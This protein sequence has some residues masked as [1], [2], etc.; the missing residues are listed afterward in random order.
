LRIAAALMLACC[1]PMSAGRAL[2]EEITVQLK[3]RHQF[4]FAGYYAALEKGF[5]AEEGLNVRLI[6]GGPGRPPVDTLLRGGADYA[7]A[8]AG[9]LRYR[10]RGQPVVVLASIFQ[11][12]PLVLLCLGRSGLARLNDLRGKRLMLQRGHAT[13]ILAMLHQ[14][15]IGKNDFRF[16][17]TSSQLGDLILGRVDAFAAYETNEPFVLQNQGIPYRMFRPRDY[18][19]DFYGDTLITTE[20]E[21]RNHPER[22]AAFRRATLRGWRYAL[23]HMDEVI[24]LIKRQYDTQHK[25]RAHLAF[26]AQGIRDLMMADVV[27]IGLSNPERWQAIARTFDSLGIPVEHVDWRVFLYR[28]APSFGSF[29]RQHALGATMAG[30]VLALLLATSYIL[31]LL[32]GRARMARLLAAMPV[33]LFVSRLDNGS[34][35]FVNDRARTFS[36][37]DDLGPHRSTL[38]FYADPAERHRIVRQILETGEIAGHE[39]AVR[40]ADGGIR[41]VS[42]SAHR[43]RFEGHDAMISVIQDITETIRSRSILKNVNQELEQRVAERTRELLD[44]NTRLREEIQERERAEQERKQLAGHLAQAQKMES[45]GVLAG[46]V[47]HDFNNLLAGIMGNAELA[48]M[49][50]RDGRMREYL[51]PIL[52]ASERGAS[53]VRHLLDYAGKSGREQ[54]TLDLHDI[55]RETVDLA[56]A[57]LSSRIRLICG[58]CTE[59]PDTPRMVVGDANQLMQVVMNLLTNAAEAHGDQAGVIHLDCGI[60][61][62]DAPA[63]RSL[64]V[65]GDMQ[66]GMHA[67]IAVRDEGRGMDDETLSR[68]FDPFFT[69]KET[70]TGLGLAAAAGIMR[71]HHGGIAVESAPGDGTRFCLYLPLATPQATAAPPATARRKQ[72]ALPRWNGRALIVDDEPV[73]RGM[74]RRMLERLGLEVHEAESGEQAVSWLSGC[75]NPVDIVLLD[76]S[77]PD[78][79]GV[80]AFHALRALRPGLR[81]VLC[82]GHAENKIAHP[83]KQAGLAGFL[84]KPYSIHR[85]AR[86]LAP[87]FD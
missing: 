21:V 42:L 60:R 86:T 3:W 56:R 20:S 16:L 8:D 68:I 25:S 36:R 87:F 47:A 58:A 85:L 39:L 70:G 10:A 79:D 15:G 64:T 65:A 43:I 78:M 53:L 2:A 52:V 4:Q 41:W 18:G 44:A 37:A 61:H 83:L 40:L 9:A 22:A 5:Y 28:P 82:S 74:G 59:E 32:R 33:P 14:R 49:E 54:E 77:M 63:I 81:I 30:V 23:D 80:Q 66:P 12:S 50:D 51:R 69:T 13:E 19:I 48:M 67:W 38:D 29:L 11:H 84:H 24:E 72:E 75:D 45:I 71:D 26:E 7:V 6:E 34:L 57:G 62:L 55:V 17:P 73:V 31:M 76:Y 1:L 46:G 35:L 27:P